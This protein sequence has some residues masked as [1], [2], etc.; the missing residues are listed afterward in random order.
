MRGPDEG[1]AFY[2]TGRPG[3][4]RDLRA[5]LHPPYTLWHLSYVVLGAMVAPRVNWTTLLATLLAFFLAVGVA[6]HALDELQGR[7]LKTNISTGALEAATIV[8]LGGAI[9]LGAVGVTRVG[10]GLV[11]FIIVGT[12]LVLAYNLELFGG[13][14]HNDLGMALSWGAFP[15]LTSAY[16]QTS[17]IS[18]SVVVLAGA[19]S[20]FT[21]AQRNLST[22]VRKLRRKVSNVDGELTMHDGSVQVIDRVSLLAPSE[23]ALRVMSW[24]M[25]ALAVAF[26]LARRG[27]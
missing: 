14:V 6:A 19:A 27:Y 9:A 22:P 12:L 11:A 24:G 3:R 10:W 17:S 15:V 23:R 26:V 5:V 2:A 4:W 18:F 13:L 21:A 25:I 20:F 7:P 16:A 8:A 1:P